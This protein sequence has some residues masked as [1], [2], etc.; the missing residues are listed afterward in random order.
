MSGS[1]AIAQRERAKGLRVRV[2]VRGLDR[3]AL[4][5]YARHKEI[6]RVIVADGDRVEEIIL[7]EESP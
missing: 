2:E 7:A 5:E 4:L 1:D 3:A 6:P